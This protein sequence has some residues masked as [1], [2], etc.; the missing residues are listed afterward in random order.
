MQ[1][2]QIHGSANRKFCAGLWRATRALLWRSSALVYWTQLLR[3]TYAF[4]G[5]GMDLRAVHS[6]PQLFDSSEHAFGK[7]QEYL[8]NSWG[9]SLKSGVW[10]WIVSIPLVLCSSA[11]VYWTQL[12]RATCALCGSRI[13]QRAARIDPQL[14]HSSDP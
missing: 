8:P 9:S 7:L 10:L 11:L 2:S 1:G 6:D 4:S 13:A 5:T 3:A 14:F 12:L